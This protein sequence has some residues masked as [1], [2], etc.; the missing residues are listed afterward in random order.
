M[1]LGSWVWADVA[2]A[3]FR[4]VKAKSFKDKSTVCVCVSTTVV[5]TFVV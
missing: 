4:D 2:D 5:R 1:L 3:G